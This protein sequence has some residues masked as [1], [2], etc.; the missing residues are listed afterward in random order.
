MK[1][2]LP[3][4]A[5]PWDP[6]VKYIFIGRDG[7]DMVWS[8]HNHLSAGTPAFYDLFKG[9]PPYDGPELE[10]PS[11]TARDMA[12]DL[13]RDDMP[14]QNL[15][16][17]WSHTRTWWAARHQPN[18]LMIHFN[19]LKADLDG[20][21]RRIADF[22]GTPDMPADR[23]ADAVEHCTFAWMKEHGDVSAPPMS[24]VV[25]K[26]GASDFINKGTNSRWKDVLSEDECRQ[27]LEKAERE[28]GK[29]CANWLQH[30]G[31]IP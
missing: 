31:P 18:L 17:F 26:N 29:E 8:A 23:W 22:L 4:D 7:R 20:Q 21:M 3:R 2:H 13:I 28:L 6:K 11:G 19:D 10:P 25:F 15:W 30:G 16:P 5:L 12:L 27:Y 24:D 1:T 9:G 14:S